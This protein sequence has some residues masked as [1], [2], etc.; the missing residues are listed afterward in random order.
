MVQDAPLTMSCEQRNILFL[1]L[2][3]VA[4]VAQD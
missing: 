1:P 2:A 3:F 4:Y